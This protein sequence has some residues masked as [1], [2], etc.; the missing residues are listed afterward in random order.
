MKILLVSHRFPPDIGG[1]ETSSRILARE[2]VSLGHD[3]RVVT[4][5]GGAT[6]EEF[7]F[8]IVRQP[9]PAALWRHVRWCD[10]CFHNNIALRMAWPLAAIRRPWVV[11]VHMWLGDDVNPRGAAWKRRLLRVVA[12][13][14]YASDALRAH[15]GLEG[16]ILPNVFDRGAFRLMAGI[17]RADDVAFLGRLV[18]DKGAEILV[19][20]LGDM[21]KDG[22]KGTAS[23]IGDGPERQ[24]V[25]RAIAARGLA[26]R[27]HC[28]GSVTGEPLARMLNAH[29]V[30]AV[31]SV[32][33]EP[34]GIVALEGAACGCAIVASDT[35][36]LRDAVGP[37][38]ETVPPGDA[39][40]L[41][42]CLSRFLKDPER[43]ARYVGAAPDHLS[44]HEPRTVALRLAKIL[45][46]AAAAH[47]NS[48]PAS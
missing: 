12:K 16:E 40:A 6:A 27:V 46:E 5:T 24:S 36:G 41:A 30:L 29:K 10:V 47:Q 9:S 18:S 17:P 8:G 15:V 13:R 34:F 42:A 26:A 21:A 37:C 43:R 2:L 31:P 23:I 11:A 39:A 25:E 35:G 3:V 19:C 7:P 32:A 20:A 1:I 38:G 48:I 44:R 4:Q 33:P 45:E 14:V 28:V 22:W